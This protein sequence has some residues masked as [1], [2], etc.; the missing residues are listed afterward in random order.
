ME[1]RGSYGDESTEF[2][3]ASKGSVNSAVKGLIASGCL[4]WAAA[5]TSQ[6]RAKEEDADSREA[7][8][9]ICRTEPAGVAQAKMVGGGDLQIAVKCPDHYGV[10][11]SRPHRSPP[12]V[13]VRLLTSAPV[14]DRAATPSVRC[15]TAI[16]TLWCP[17]P[18][19]MRHDS[20][21][22]VGW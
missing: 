19:V 11:L 14:K 16:G 2:T 15:L 1:G 8:H 17:A 9:V 13:R 22:N 12:S 4:E 3:L 6:E 5:E 7:S 21:R 10:W 20:V 18:D